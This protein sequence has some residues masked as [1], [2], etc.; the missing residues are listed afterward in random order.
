MLKRSNS[1]NSNAVNQ[2][3]TLVTD[4]IKFDKLMFY[5]SSALS[6]TGSLTSSYNQSYNTSSNFYIGSNLPTVIENPHWGIS[7]VPFMNKTTGQ[8]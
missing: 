7:G 5:T 4:S 8:K 3:Y 2:T 1:T 6:I